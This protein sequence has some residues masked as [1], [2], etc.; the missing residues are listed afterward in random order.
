[1]GA[2]P[3][4]I[5]RWFAVTRY[6]ESAPLALALLALALLAPGA[7]AQFGQGG[8][9][10]FGPVVENGENAE[11][12]GAK[13]AIEEDMIRRLRV[14]SEGASRPSARVT[15][16]PYERF[17]SRCRDHADAAGNPEPLACD[18][19]G[20]A[21]EA[22]R[23]IGYQYVILIELSSAPGEGGGT[24][25]DFSYQIYKTNPGEVAIN[26]RFE[27]NSLDLAGAMR[28]LTKQIAYGVGF[29]DSPEFETAVASMRTESSSAFTSYWLG[30]GHLALGAYDQAYAAFEAAA[31][32]DPAYEEPRVHMGHVH[33]AK[34]REHQANGEWEEGLAAIDQ[35]LNVYD[36]LRSYE[37]KAQALIVKADIMA[38]LGRVQDSWTAR[39]TA[40][41]VYMEAGRIPEGFL[42]ADI[43]YREMEAA[44]ADKDVDVLWLLGHAHRV[45]HGRLLVNSEKREIMAQ[46][47][48]AEIF[49]N[50]VLVADP[51]YVP[52]LLDRGY[53]YKSYGEQYATDTEEQMAWRQQWL[54]WALADFTA[55][56]AVQPANWEAY[57]EMGQCLTAMAERPE[58]ASDKEREVAAGQFG[59]AVNHFRAALR[60]LKDQGMD[61]SPEAGRICQRLSYI[62]RH[63]GRPD[64]AVTVINRAMEILGKGEADI[65]IE[66]ILIQVE[67]GEFDA[68][69]DILTEALTHFD[70]PPDRLTAMDAKIAAAKDAWIEGEGW[71]G[72]HRL[73]GTNHWDGGDED[74]Q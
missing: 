35:A 5:P 52:A 70:R 24:R 3:D 12:R 53:M 72:P 60:V 21:K 61:A 25:L 58:G 63:L 46:Y 68:A 47:A 67:S 1:M 7:C 40:A 27:G 56:T 74:E 4:R 11:I 33:L 30:R 34:A 6:K 10:A 2:T 45:R 31:A 64:E 43:V 44:G 15:V 57:R 50:D 42:E 29:Y 16:H 32:A 59:Q 41:R 54:G 71:G 65:W 37:S 73:E 28:S 49:L 20:Q 13:L 22:A 66:M 62:L 26:Q 19:W 14:A 69:Q 36:A 39:K 51:H 8:S 18:T 17:L 38:A 48:D 9:A 55:V 23:L